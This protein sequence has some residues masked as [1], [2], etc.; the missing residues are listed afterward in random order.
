[1]GVKV[2]EKN[3]AW[4]LF[5]DHR[6][7]RKAKCVG[8]GKAGKRAAEAAA[9][10]IQSK[11]TLGDLSIFDPPAEVTNVDTFA[12]VAQ[13]WLT[14][15][16]TLHAIR[17]TT[18][19]NYRSFMTQHLLPA[20]GHLPITEVTT[21]TIEDFIEAKRLPGGSIRFQGKPLSDASL[22]T[23]L[24]T[25]RLIL[26]RA[27]RTKRIP[28]NP[29]HEVEWRGTPRINNVDR[30]TGEELRAVL[31]AAG[32]RDADLATLL[33]L[34]AQSGMRAGEVCGLQWQDL[35]LVAGTAIVRRT[36]SRQRLGP[37]KTGH[38]RSVSI[39]HPVTDKTSEWRPGTTAACW[40][41]VAGL[42]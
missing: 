10:K 28:A 2:R 15:C 26:R 22:R 17:P 14:K 25:L 6:G 34:W 32:E 37:T 13:E 30:F 40:T 41:V 4:W 33:R 35:D 9:E 19:D 12:E 36:W 7:K 27:V 29:M 3:G 39:L 1:M 11:L 16:P 31:A 24:L 20:L 21:T 18:L 8:T 5:I 42:S 38:E 23:G